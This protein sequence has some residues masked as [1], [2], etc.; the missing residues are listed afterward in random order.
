MKTYAWFIELPVYDKR[1]KNPIYTV[2][3]IVMV[4]KS[5]LETFGKD[6][7]AKNALALAINKTP[8]ARTDRKATVYLGELVN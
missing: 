3:N 5:E 6:M 4:T 2:A 8:K 1:T 7:T